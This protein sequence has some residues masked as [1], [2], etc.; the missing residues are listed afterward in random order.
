MEEKYSDILLIV[1][2]S[3]TLALI[4]DLII[5]NFF[6]LISF[7]NLLTIKGLLMKIQTHNNLM[8]YMSYNN[9]VV[10]SV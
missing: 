8:H 4:R 5:K 9:R 3:L 6:V 1:P 10:K 7:I 2:W